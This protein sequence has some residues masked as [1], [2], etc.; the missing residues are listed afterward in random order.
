[1]NRARSVA[2]EMETGMDYEVHVSLA[3]AATSLVFIAALFVSV[4]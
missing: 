4:L 1:M 3:M 2:V